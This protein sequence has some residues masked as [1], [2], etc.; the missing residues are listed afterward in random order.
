VDYAVD[1][2]LSDISREERI[3]H[4]SLEAIT[5][6]TAVAKINRSLTGKTTL[7][8]SRTIKQ[9]GLVDYHRPTATKD[10]HG[11]WNGPAPVVWNDPDRGMVVCRSG[12]RELNVRYPDVRRSMYIETIFMIDTG[13]RDEALGTVIQY[14]ASLYLQEKSLRC[15]A[16][17][18]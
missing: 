8:G 10:E 6:A 4:A 18:L 1:G 7:D 12:G 2:E 3:R 13:L 5:Q 17:F 14:I 11:G 16:S 9:G 15:M